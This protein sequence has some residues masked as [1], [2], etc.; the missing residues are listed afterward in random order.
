MLKSGRS[1]R[2]L[3]K[4]TPVA[5]GLSNS[6]SGGEAGGGCER[7]H[8]ASTSAAA[9]SAAHLIP[10]ASYFAGVKRIACPPPGASTTFRFV[11][12]STILLE[13]L[14]GKGLL[15]QLAPGPSA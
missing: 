3:A 10:T 1:G 14:T 15:T 13:I 4:V 2:L 12:E 6:K 7:S 11:L 5:S 8:A 9:A